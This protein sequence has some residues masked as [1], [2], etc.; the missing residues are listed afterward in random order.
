MYAFDPPVCPF[1]SVLRGEFPER[2]NLGK[3]EMEEE[4]SKKSQ[5]QIKQAKRK[6]RRERRTRK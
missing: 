6:R 2:A 3:G 5:K 1:V 4:M